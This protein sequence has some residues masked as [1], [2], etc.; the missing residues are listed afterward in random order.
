MPPVLPPN[1]SARQQELASFQILD[2]PPDSAFDH[3]VTL[4]AEICEASISVVSFS[5][6]DRQWVKAIY[7]F[8]ADQ[9]PREYSFCSHAILKPHE[10]LIVPDATKDPRFAANPSVTGAP[11][12]RFY[13]GAP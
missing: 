3:L 7:G 11:N 12:I 8:Q 2:T 5:D 9:S 1:E 13:A 6:N 4:A 10:M